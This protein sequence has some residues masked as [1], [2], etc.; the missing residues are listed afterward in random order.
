LIAL[1]AIKQH[2]LP[3]VINFAPIYDKSKDGYDWI[4]ACKILKDAGADVVGFNCSRGPQTLLPLLKKLRRAVDG[5]IAAVP[6]PYNTSPEY[7][8]F[9]FLK[10]PDGSSAYTLGLDQHLCTRDQ[11]ADFAVQA[12]KLGVSFIG[13]CCGA[14]PHHIRAIA[15]AL[16]RTTPASKYSPNFDRH[17]LLGAATFV[18]HSEKQFL[19]QWA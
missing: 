2:D 18:K 19:E 7:P 13:L 5:P 8:S 4:E 15:E 17:S 6:V 14:G 11:A 10:N 3:A 12:R 9:Q 1:E 16:G